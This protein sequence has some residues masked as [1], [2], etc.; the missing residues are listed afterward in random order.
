MIIMSGGQTGADRAGLDFAI[1]NNI[2]H[3]GFCPRGRKA[4]DGP[5]DLKYNLSETDSA[6]YS[7]R[8]YFNVFYADATLIFINGDLTK[9]SAYTEVVCKTQNKKYKIIN[10]MD[11][12]S[13][14]NLKDWIEQHKIKSLNIAGS[15][16]SINPGIYQLTKTYLTNNI[17][18]EK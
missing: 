16:E 15:R 8:T 5:L 7:R 3:E 17:I 6:G 14:F 11:L 2:P 13:D 9:G 12:N 4:E 18:G 10:F 1:E